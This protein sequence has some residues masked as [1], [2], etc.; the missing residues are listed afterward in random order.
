V[1]AATHIRCTGGCTPTQPFSGV[2]L[3]RGFVTAWRSVCEFDV[4]GHATALEY[5]WFGPPAKANAFLE[6]NFL[7]ADLM[8]ARRD[9]QSTAR[10]NGALQ[11][12]DTQSGELFVEG[13]RVLLTPATQ[14]AMPRGYDYTHALS[15]ADLATGKFVTVAGGTVGGTITA[16]LISIES[17]P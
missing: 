4:D 16:D 5:C 8:L 9:T 12:V 11:S 14:I 15:I 13:Q 7:S 17:V 1:L 2:G 10:L 6:I 3:R